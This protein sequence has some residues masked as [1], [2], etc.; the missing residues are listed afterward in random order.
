MRGAEEKRREERRT[1]DEAQKADARVMPIARTFPPYMSL[2]SCTAWRS[3]SCCRS[4]HVCL[5][6]SFS[7]SRCGSSAATHLSKHICAFFAHSAASACRRRHRHQHSNERRVS[8]SRSQSQSQNGG[9]R[10]ATSLHLHGVAGCVRETGVLT[11]IGLLPALL[12]PDYRLPPVL[13]RRA[14]RIDK[15]H[16]LGVVMM[17]GLDSDARVLQSLRGRLALCERERQADD[18]VTMSRA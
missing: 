11:A 2:Y 17:C 3:P 12:V 16:R 5:S 14:H 1:K 8:R 4:S 10:D 18:G 15:V 13:L 7:S 9:A 6:S